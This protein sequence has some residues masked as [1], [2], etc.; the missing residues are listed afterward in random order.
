MTDSY[1]RAADAMIALSRTLVEA[2]S[3]RYQS[4]DRVPVDRPEVSGSKDVANPTLDT[5]LDQRRSDLSDEVTRV[6]F[7]LRRVAESLEGANHALT[8]D[9][10]AWN[11]EDI[12]D[13]TDS[14]K[15]AR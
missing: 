5:V 10:A 1:R 7:L 2:R 11:D 8:V 3:V 15:G 4:P 14:I 6:D 9:L 12:K 13:L